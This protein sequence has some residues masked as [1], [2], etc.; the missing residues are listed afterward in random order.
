[1]DAEIG[2]MPVE[3]CPVLAEL[4]RTRRAVGKTGQVFEGLAALSTDSNLRII[5]A[6]MRET[7]AVRTLDVGLSFGGSAL[8]FCASHKQ[9]GRSPE[10]QHVAIDPFQATVWDSCGL[11]AVERAG[12]AGY[13]DLRQAYSA[14]EL[15]RLVEAGTRFGLVYVDGSHLFEDVFV[16]A[17]FITRL[18]VEGGIVAFDDSSNPH[19]A[20]VLR[21]LRKSLPRSLEELDLS[22]YRERRERVR[23]RVARYLG[24]VQMTAFRRV[25]NLERRWD[26]PFRPF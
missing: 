14:L 23:Y 8:A 12:L 25:G 15:P 18:L 1:M 22:K 3:F 6:L 7:R 19:V 17:Y 20:K 11:M 9:L 26:A 5:H 16:D 13:M 4:L 10:A 24:K 21:F 2:K